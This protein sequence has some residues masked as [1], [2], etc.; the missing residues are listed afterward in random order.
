M[1]PARIQ[2]GGLWAAA[3]CLP[4]IAHGASMFVN[5]EP[6]AWFSIPAPHRWALAADALLYVAGCVLV[7][8][9]V[10]GVAGAAHRKAAAATPLAMTDGAR[11]AWPLLIAVLLF[12]ASS[13]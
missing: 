1:K 4:A 11:I 8:A 2:H 5:V 9:P 3:A 13:S 7:A 10:A 12:A 6:G